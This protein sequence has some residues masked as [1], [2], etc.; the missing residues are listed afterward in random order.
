MDNG[1]HILYTDEDLNTLGQVMGNVSLTITGTSHIVGDVYGGG[2]LSDANSD[3]TKTTTV[4]ILDGTYDGNIYGGGQGRLADV[5][6][7]IDAVAAKVN[8]VVTVNIGSID[9]EGNVSGNATLRSS[10]VFG[11]NNI[12]GSPQADVFVNVYKAAQ[13][14]GVNTVA[15]DGYAI[16]QVFGGGNAADYAPAGSNKA[17]VHV[18]TCYNTI[19]RVFGGGNAA[20]A[21]EVMN[22]VDG[23]RFDWVYGGGNGEVT[24]ANIVGD[25]TLEVNGGTIDHLLNGSNHSGTIG[26]TIT[27]TIT[28]ESGC[29]TGDDVIEE[30]F[31]GNNE[32][33]IGASGLTTTIACSPLKTPAHIVNLYGG[34]N[35]ASIDGPVTLNLYGGHIDNVYAGSKGTNEI[36]ANIN[37]DVTLNLYGGTVGN[38]FG[39]CDVNGAISGLITV[40]VFENSDCPL[41]ITNVYGGGNNAAYAPTFAVGAGEKRIAPRV[42]ILKGRVNNDVFGGGL[43]ASATVTAN[44]KV[45]VGEEVESTTY[46]CTVGGNLF[47]G[48][49]Q[50]AVNGDT[51]VHLLNKSVI[52]GNVYG[53]GNEATVDGDTKVIVNGVPLEP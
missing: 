46:R 34:S 29:G 9:G 27:A 24:A 2:A 45:V 52:V 12:N 22:I 30:Y 16:D 31:C 48:G 49:S 14:D 40:N 33:P 19:R 10:S 32:A 37:G 42:N 41:V 5:D 17:T 25:V 11:C 36:A 18:Y 50:A 44:P 51:E 1:A 13:S 35:Q 6:N 21:R 38:A 8:G 3:D 43:G 26:G 23:G 47:G 28:N 53:G 39:G 15:D 4:N 7:D 20:A